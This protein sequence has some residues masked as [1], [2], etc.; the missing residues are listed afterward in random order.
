MTIALQPLRNHSPA[1][2]DATRRV[3]R[4]MK[5]SS[6]LRLVAPRLLLALG[7]L[8]LNDRQCR[9]P[10]IG[11]IIRIYAAELSFH[12]ALCTL[13]PSTPTDDPSQRHA[14]THTCVRALP[15]RGT[16]GLSIT[17]RNSPRITEPTGVS[18]SRY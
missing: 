5:N 6:C 3:I 4:E 10:R 1:H 7:D 12:V 15:R 14:R 13:S 8:T 16:H 9:R 11:L 17:R 2:C 18:S